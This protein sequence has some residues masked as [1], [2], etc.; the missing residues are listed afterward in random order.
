MRIKILVLGLA[1]LLFVFMLNSQELDKSSLSEI[2]S[3]IDSMAEEIGG[4]KIKTVLKKE[5]GVVNFYVDSQVKNYTWKASYRDYKAINS[6]VT[7]VGSIMD[8]ICLR[9]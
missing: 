1:C 5:N 4:I 2:A 7:S 9:V 6:I 3:L 8:H